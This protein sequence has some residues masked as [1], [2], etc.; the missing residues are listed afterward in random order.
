MYDM[1]IGGV[2]GTMEPPLTTALRELGE[3]LGLG[4]YGSSGS[5]LENQGELLPFVLF[6]G[7]RPMCSTVALYC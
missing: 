6:P 5:A 3:E 1:F 7:R 2:S 4:P